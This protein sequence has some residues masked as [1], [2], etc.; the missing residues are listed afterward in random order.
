MNADPESEISALKNQVFFLLVALMM[1]SGT[2]MVVLYRQAS[3][4]RK[5]IDA[6]KTQAAPIITVY[7]QNAALI[8][9]FVNQLKAYGQAHPDFVPVLAKYGLAAAPSTPAVAPPLAA[10]PVAAPKK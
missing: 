9:S 2:L 6:L 8:D 1:L 10:P 7:N 3:M 4:A 5:E